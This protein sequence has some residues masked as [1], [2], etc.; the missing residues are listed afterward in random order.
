[1]NSLSAF[2]DTVAA[3]LLLTFCGY[4]DVA[5]I[6]AEYSLPPENEVMEKTGSI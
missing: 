3:V 5:A 1:M 6:E 2:F 4:C